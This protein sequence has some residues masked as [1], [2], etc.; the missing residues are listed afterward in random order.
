MSIREKR[1]RSYRN[2]RPVFVTESVRSS[3]GSTKMLDLFA[4]NMKLNEAL[5]LLYHDKNRSPEIKEA[6]EYVK[7]AQSRMRAYSERLRNSELT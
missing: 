6:I 5:E 1:E 3:S 7:L 2:V 4:T